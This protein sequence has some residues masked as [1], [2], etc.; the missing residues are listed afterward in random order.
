MEL[1]AGMLLLFAACLF[2][3]WWNSEKKN[4]MPDHDTNAIYD[5]AATNNLL[6]AKVKCLELAIK[7]NQGNA[8][9]ADRVI[10]DAQKFW[11]FLTLESDE[12][13]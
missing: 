3:S 13:E 5:G 8:M 2:L 10:E 11:D 12:D 9:V 6:E 1:L 7:N 4:E